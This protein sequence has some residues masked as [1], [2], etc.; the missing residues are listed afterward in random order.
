MRATVIVGVKSDD[1]GLGAD[2]EKWRAA[3]SQGRHIRLYAA[4]K[5]RQIP[6]HQPPAHS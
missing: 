1:P 3:R 6:G 5:T 4:A 2:G